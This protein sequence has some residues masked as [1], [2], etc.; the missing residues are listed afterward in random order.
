[1][2]VARGPQWPRGRFSVLAGFV[3][4]GES[5]EACVAREVFEEVGVRVRDVHYLGSQPWPFPRSLMIGFEARADRGA[6]LRPAEREIAEARWVGREEVRAA[7][8]AGSWAD[9][10][11]PV[12]GEHPD[13]VLPGPVSIAGQMLASW[14]AARP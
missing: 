3:E 10:A 2:L 14:A 7:L 11:G 6:P 13:L 12:H 5:L 4:A 9:R 1:V 8:A